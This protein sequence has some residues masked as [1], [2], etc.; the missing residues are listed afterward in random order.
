ML[1]SLT[2]RWFSYATNDK[3]PLGKVFVFLQ[4]GF[5]TL[6]H[7]IFHENIPVLFA[8]SKQGQCLLV[9]Y[10]GK[11]VPSVSPF[12]S[13]TQG[14]LLKQFPIFSVSIAFCWINSTSKYPRIMSTLLQSFKVLITKYPVVR[15][16][17][18]YSL[19][20]PASSLIQQTFEGKRWGKFQLLFYRL[21]VKNGF[22]NRK[23]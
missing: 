18:S 17:V 6:S 5:L 23:L 13:I 19:I 16:M 1:F 8:F 7:A 22:F 21:I 15:G 4:N 12:W 11:K 9:T 3:T 20:W 10:W 14:Y 2:L